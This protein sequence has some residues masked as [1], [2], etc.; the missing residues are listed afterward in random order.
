MPVVPYEEPV[1]IAKFAVEV[2][3]VQ[4]RINKVGLPEWEVP[5]AEMVNGG[6]AYVRKVVSGPA[7]ATELVLT[8]YIDGSAEDATFRDLFRQT[9]NP[10]GTSQGSAERSTIA[11]ISLNSAGSE[12]ERR[13]YH[14]CFPTK[15]TKSEQDAAS[16]DLET[17]EFTFAVDWWEVA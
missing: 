13:I 1:P 7:K 10:T 16:T 17:E 11:V 3:N 15:H 8:R 4:V 9:F 14:D 2:N 12:V 6:D 5:T